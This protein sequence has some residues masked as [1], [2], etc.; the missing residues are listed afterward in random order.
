M[1]DQ[2][3]VPCKFDGDCI[4]F[5]TEEHCSIHCEFYNP[6]DDSILKDVEVMAD[7]IIKKQK[8]KKD[9]NLKFSALPK[10]DKLHEF[11][12]LKRH[13]FEMQSISPK[14]IILKFKRKL[15][16]TDTIADGCY[17]F[18]DKEDKLLIPHKVFAKFDREAKKKRI[19]K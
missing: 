4:N 13:V 11:I 18:V 8:N 15:T 16:K 9:I 14:K 3:P 10:F 17:V 1:S 7:E 2:T 19:K 5:I 12:V 6:I